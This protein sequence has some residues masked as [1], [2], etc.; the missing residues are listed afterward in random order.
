MSSSSVA[1]PIT[2][3]PSSPDPAPRKVHKNPNR[4]HPYYLSPLT[5]P[6][7]SR[8]PTPMCKRLHNH[9]LA[10]GL[11]S[12]RKPRHGRLWPPR[13]CCYPPLYGSRSAFPHPTPD[14]AGVV[15]YRSYAR[16]HPADT[17]LRPMS[18]PLGEKTLAA[19]PIPLDNLAADPDPNYEGLQSRQ[20]HRAARWS[21]HQ[22]V[23]SSSGRRYRAA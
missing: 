19:V 22:N 5:H 8:C 18:T 14:F 20:G 2:C 16:A 23:W 17:N 7:S 1:Q 10:R 6:C 3:R 11:A 9:D 4:A 13:R 15:E 21:R 12:G